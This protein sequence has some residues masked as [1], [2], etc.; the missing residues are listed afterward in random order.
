M[1]R[2]KPCDNTEPHEPHEWIDRALRQ[3]C[4]GEQPHAADCTGPDHVDTYSWPQVFIARHR[5][6]C[7]P[8]QPA[9]E[10]P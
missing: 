7:S 6:C 8:P 4:P 5:R 3:D 10:T 9:K 2:R 1:S